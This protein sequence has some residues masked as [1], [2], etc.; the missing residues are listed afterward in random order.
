MQERP[1][2]SATRVA[3][4]S[5]EHHHL[6]FVSTDLHAG[7]PTETRSSVYQTLQIIRCSGQQGRFISIAQVTQQCQSVLGLDVSIELVLVHAPK[8]TVDLAG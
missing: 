2:C 8:Q 1:H 4:A 5:R 7:V 3:Q 6:G